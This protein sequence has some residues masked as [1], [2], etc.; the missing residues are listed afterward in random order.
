MIFAMTREGGSIRD[1][2]VSNVSVTTEAPLARLLATRGPGV[3]RDFEL[4]DWRITS[5]GVGQVYDLQGAFVPGTLYHHNV[6]MV[7]GVD[8][9]E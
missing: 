9:E 4:Y 8:R 5:G 2:R 3:M 7:E 6:R 1:L